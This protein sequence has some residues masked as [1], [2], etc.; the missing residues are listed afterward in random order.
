MPDSLPLIGRTISHYRIIEKLGGGGMGVVYKAEDT[1]LGRFVALKFLPDDVASDPQ[2]LERFRREA[3]AA[4]ALNHPNI[5]TIYEI[6][7][8]DGHPFIV[9]EFL[10]GVTL[11]HM[12]TAKPMPLDRLL[13]VAI[14][15]A[16]GLDAA[17]AERIIHRDIKPANVFVTKRGHAKILDFGLA[18]VTAAGKLGDQSDGS[19]TQGVRETELTSPGT[20]LGTV[21]Y[22]SPEQVRGQSLDART[23]LFSFGVV[24]YE[25]ATGALPFRGETSGLITD[26]ILNRAPVAPVR[27]NPDLPPQ[28][29]QI[30]TKALEKDRDLRYQHASEIRADLKRL[31]RDTNT[32]RTAVQ[33]QPPPIPLS[34][35]AG[36][37]ARTMEEFGSSP[38]RKSS[39]GRAVIAPASTAEQETGET[40]AKIP[41]AKIAPAA[42][43]VVALIAAGLYW[44]S[45]Q[46]GKLNEKD[47]IVLADFSNTT[48]DALFDDTLKQALAIQLEQSPFLNVLSGEKVSATLKLMNQGVHDRLTQDVAR[49]VCVRTSSK[50]MLAGSI[51]AI[52][53]HYLIGLKAMNCQTG[54]TLGS[55]EEEASNRDD[56]LKA[57][58]AAGNQLRQKLGESLAS[59]QK[60]G[61]PLDQVTTSSLEALK[62]Y[63]QG[64][65]A[66][67][68]NES[69]AAFPYFKRAVQLDPNFARAYAALGTYYSAHSEASLAIEN[70]S[71]AFELR[72]RVSERE[73]YYIEA[74][75]YAYVTG[76]Q[77]K[78]EQTYLQWTQA[79]PN[80][81]TAH[82]NLGVVYST[83]GE[84]E[85]AAE[86]AR[87]SNR[88]AP[89]VVT[90]GNLIGIY[91][92]LNRF[93]EAKQAF[94]RAI[95]EKLDG[96]GLRLQRYYLA[97]VQGDSAAM[98]EQ[99]RWA[100]GKAGIEDTLLSTQSD[101]EAYNGQISK[102][103]D[104][105][106]RAAESAK[107]SGAPEAA[108]IWLANGALREA[109]FGNGAK[110]RDYISEAL[111]LKSGR[112]V[113]LFSAIAFARSGDSARSQALVD[114]LSRDFP[115]DTMYQRY[116]LPTIQASQELDRGNAQRAI[117]ILSV[118]ANFDLYAPPQFQTEPIYPA[119]IRGEAYLKLGDGDKAAQEFRKLLDQRGMVVNFPLGALAQLGLARAY[120]LE[121]RSAGGSDG[122]AG[123]A[124]ARTAYQ[125]LFAMWKDADPDLPVLVAAKSEY[126]K[127]K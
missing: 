57:L 94:D 78:A 98:Q 38:S 33:A 19:T 66:Q 79:Y 96:P 125:D 112:D 115:L 37:A 47:T 102:A 87:E 63:S 1:E 95:E 92:A 44:R 84:Y 54:D 89:N 122:G 53:S 73:R 100:A 26:G 74:T 14:E 127:L 36:T 80:D 6:G 28:L 8:Q 64:V 15:V 107:R 43:V 51:A 22:M 91:L 25:M 110:A 4:S 61:R 101:T 52:G 23:D 65:H 7:Q 34:D 62:A 5:C 93:D 29:E 99:V 77:E 124:K 108:A 71:K 49:E 55:A 56:V 121:A 109:E 72:D 70:Y 24:I 12:V 41:W 16:D 42:L 103:R 67:Y 9:M 60:F 50:A 88:L 97:F 85:K 18:K 45:R 116:W 82:N 69:D 114:K 27:L 113:E 20:A 21:A 13:E 40:R 76:E 3:R 10:D 117:D 104:T 123:L 30:I 35:S 68:A 126:S 48:G 59:V 46:S 118:N 120:G 105:T 119:F 31:K 17:H 75:Y 111:A 90:Y 81:D 32:G 39:G 58:G 106:R 83:L 2:S 11:K 86:Q